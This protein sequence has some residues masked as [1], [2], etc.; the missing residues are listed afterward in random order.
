M[1]LNLRSGLAISITF[2]N[3]LHSLFRM[4]I[5]IILYHSYMIWVQIKVTYAVQ[6]TNCGLIT[7]MQ[8]LVGRDQ[9]LFF[10]WWW[11]FEILMVWNWKNNFS[12]LCS[13]FWEICPYYLT[14]FK[15]P[16]FLDGHD[17]LIRSCNMITY[18]FCRKWEVFDYLALIFCVMKL[19]RTRGSIVRL[20]VHLVWK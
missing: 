10:L 9:Y 20:R 7:H 3:F 19:H 12:W 13:L 17:L 11:S 4:C 8:I 15:C 6:I 1:I 5:R 14:P 18:W 16:S 2:D